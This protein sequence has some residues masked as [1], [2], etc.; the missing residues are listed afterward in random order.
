[1]IQHPLTYFRHTYIFVVIRMSNIVR[2]VIDGILGL[3]DN[4]LSCRSIK[5][6]AQTTYREDTFRIVLYIWWSVLLLSFLVRG[7]EEQK[8]KGKSGQVF[9][10]RARS[11]KFQF[12]SLIY[13]KIRKI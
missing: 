2:G 3:P 7:V 5:I 4:C 11:F 12:W 13:Q 8:L 6:E 1:M 10:I 9:L